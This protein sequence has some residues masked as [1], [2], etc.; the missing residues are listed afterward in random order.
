MT[1][2]SPVDAAGRR[3]ARRDTINRAVALIDSADPAALA[4]WLA[5]TRV[6]AHLQ[7]DPAALRGN[8]TSAA[9]GTPQ[10]FS[11]WKVSQQLLQAAGL[12]Y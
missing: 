7:A 3:A 6:H 2:P 11:A 9:D 5:Q 1:Y 8:L 4:H 10:A 12:P